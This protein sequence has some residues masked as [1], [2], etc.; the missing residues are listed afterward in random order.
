VRFWRMRCS[1][2]RLSTTHAHDPHDSLRIH[3]ECDDIDDEEYEEMS[4]EG[5]Y[6]ECLLCRGEQKERCD[7]FHR[8]KRAY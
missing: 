6:Y 7:R 8:D 2:K 3:T 1:V 5:S 4:E